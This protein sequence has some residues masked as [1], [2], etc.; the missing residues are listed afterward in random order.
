MDFL[1]VLAQ[2]IKPELTQDQKEPNLFKGLKF[3]DLLNRIDRAKGG[4]N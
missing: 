4:L 1:G 2:R 3:F